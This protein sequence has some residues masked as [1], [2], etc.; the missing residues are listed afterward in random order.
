MNRMKKIL[1][2][3]YVAKTLL[4]FAILVALISALFWII[5]PEYYKGVPNMVLGELFVLIL[6]A[7]K[8]LANRCWYSWWA[9]AILVSCNVVN[10]IYLTTD[11]LGDDYQSIYALTVVPLSFTL[12]F[13]AIFKK[14]KKDKV[15]PY[16]DNYDGYGGK[17]SE[18]LGNLDYPKTIA[19]ESDIGGGVLIGDK[20]K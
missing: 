1:L 17:S 19:R 14:P 16:G 3:A 5:A 11:I 6:L 7:D 8:L 20:P 15:V 2:K 13:V 4:F 9:Y 18:G 12:A 10:I